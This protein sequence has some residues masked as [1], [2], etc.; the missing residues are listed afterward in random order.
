MPDSIDVGPPF[1]LQAIE[2]GIWDPY[3]PTV[4]DEIPDTLKDPDG[5]WIAAYYGIMSIG[6]NTTLVADVPTSFADLNDPQYEGQVSLNGDPRE[7][8]AAFAGVWAAALANGGS[9]D[10]IMPGIEYFADLKEQ[11]ILSQS[12]PTTTTILSGETPIV[13]DWTYNWPGRLEDIADA[14]FEWSS[15]VPS[16]GVY[17]SYYAQGVVADSPAPQRRPAVDRAHPLRRRRP[18][19]PRG[20]RHPGPLR[21]ARRERHDHRGHAR[22]P[23]PGRADRADRLPDG[24]P[25]R[26]RPG[27]PRR[28][29]GA[30]G[31]RRLSRAMTAPRPLDRRDR[32]SPHGRRRGRDASSP[33]RPGAGSRALRL[34]Q[35]A[36]AWAGLIPFFLFLGLFLVVP[37]VVGV[38][39]GVRADRGLRRPGDA[40]GGERNVPRLLHR[41][42]PAVR[43]QRRARRLD[44]HVLA[45]VVVRLQ[46]PRW[47][48]TASLAFSGVA[49]NMG[50]IILAFAFIAALG[51]QGLATK[52]IKTV[53]IELP[54]GFI[55]G[56]WG[57]VTVYLFFQIPLM[58]LVMLPAVDGLKPAWRE[59]V[60]NLGGTAATYWRRVGIPVL[61]PAALGGMLLLFAN[62]FAAYATAYSLSTGAS[63]LVSVQI[64]FFLQGNTITGKANLGY[65]LAAWMIVL[66]LVTIAVYLLLRRRAERWRR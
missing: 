9:F 63:K 64:R 62:A 3:M 20:R 61:A 60:A 30:D 8:G 35:E 14:G 58:F 57:L 28:E 38:R 23:A 66:M 4:W 47:L 24:R 43:R 27:G 1:A 48:R 36:A 44:R 12:P 41:V 5:N 11:G 46:R 40:R 33:P 7:A 22:Q 59:A 52:I 6:T 13:L 18:R 21:D 56:F 54:V 31:R 39:Q 26:R 50:G 65:A 51:T 34:R 19:L 29:L 17:G 25:D 37:T 55:T 16:D 10:D 42:A 32:R 2:E 15:A 53:G 49:A 45:L